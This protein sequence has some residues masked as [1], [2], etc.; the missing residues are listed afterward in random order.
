MPTL[1]TNVHKIERFAT[2]S[3][4]ANSA[5]KSL[6][7]SHSVVLRGRH[8]SQLSLRFTTGVFCL[9]L[10]VSVADLGSCAHSFCSLRFY[11]YYL[12]E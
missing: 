6:E 7:D 12:F 5:M 2:F 4:E 9:K 11:N 10:E 8:S 3:I 1:V